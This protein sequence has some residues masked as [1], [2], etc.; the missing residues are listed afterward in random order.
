MSYDDYGYNYNNSSLH[1][2]FS[3]DMERATGYH[4]HNESDLYIGLMEYKSALKKHKFALQ[5]QRELNKK[6]MAELKSLRAVTQ[7]GGLSTE[8]IAKLKESNK[9]LLNTVETLKNEVATLKLDAERNRAHAMQSENM[10]NNADEAEYY[11]RRAVKVGKIRRGR[12]NQLRLVYGLSNE[13]LAKQLGVETSTFMHYALGTNNLPLNRAYKLA[14]LLGVE[15]GDLFENVEL[16][17]DR[18]R[19]VRNKRTELVKRIIAL[20]R[21]NMSMS[22]IARQLRLNRG[23]VKEM[24]RLYEKYNYGLNAKDTA[25]KIPTIE[26]YSRKQLGLSQELLAQ[27]AGVAL[28]RLARFEQGKHLLTDGEIISIAGVLGLN[29][30]I[31]QAQ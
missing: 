17:N 1:D 14:N 10:V 12:L 23:F 22:E 28:H 13:M 16:T 24:L 7:G 2:T 6:L 26:I 5:K 11:A 8:E 3:E 9:M 18:L 27:R 21:S 15:L 25:F 31:V 20:H 30:E 4:E 19:T 29:P